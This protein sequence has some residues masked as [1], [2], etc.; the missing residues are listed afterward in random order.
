MYSKK[1]SVC[2]VLFILLTV[3]L[4]LISCA[5]TK[6]A[7]IE[8][9]LWEVEDKRNKIVV[10]SDLHLGIDDSYT[11]TLANRQVLIDFLNRLCVTSDVRELVIAGDFLDAWYLPVYYPSYTDEVKF[12][13]AVVKNNQET[14]DAFKKV[15]DSGIKLVYVPGNHDLTL[16]SSVLDEAIPGIV[17]SSDAQG[18]GAYY[19]GDRHEIV[20]EHG[21]R[22]DVFSAPDTLSNAELCGNAE[23]MLPAG[24]FYARY[25]AT[26]VLEGRPK[27]EKDLPLVSIVP[28]KS[29]ADQFGAYIYYSLLRD[30]TS[31]MTP[32]EALEEKI[33]KMHIAG[34]DDD[35]TFLDFYPCLQED[36]EISA[37][38]LYRNIQ[39]TWADRQTLNNVKIHN[40]FIEAVAGT[41]D[42]SYFAMQARRQYLENPNENVDVVV[43]GHTHVPSLQVMENGKAYV[44]SGTWIDHN[45]DKPDATCTLAVITTGQ[46]DAS[47]LY[48]YER[49]GELTDI[50]TSAD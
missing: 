50:G 39:R 30:I 47:A 15:I 14:I 40:G 17:Q 6:D 34:F 7:A 21:H 13:K 23:T 22:Y 12:Y 35:Y 1:T 38:T 36:G 11:E 48:Q 37:P 46:S 45:T 20:I 41:V 8:K 19:T 2:A 4:L 9:P 10:I 32:Q 26:W 16:E 24:Y 44:N 43:F 25:A 18:L 29:D 28:D 31:R 27:V 33:F 49:N 3:S 5:H 42:W